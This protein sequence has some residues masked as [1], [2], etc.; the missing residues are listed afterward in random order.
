MLAAVQGTRL[1]MEA[2]GKDAAAASQAL[3]ELVDTGFGEE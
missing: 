3:A 1:V 2:R